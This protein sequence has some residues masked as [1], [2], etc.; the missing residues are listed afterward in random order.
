M[1]NALENRD[2][3]E[4]LARVYQ[5]SIIKIEQAYSLLQSAH[6]NL[7][8]AYSSSFH[9]PRTSPKSNLRITGRTD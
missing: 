9:F 7:A 1:E 4:V 8:K 6:E 3:L 5:D 2:T